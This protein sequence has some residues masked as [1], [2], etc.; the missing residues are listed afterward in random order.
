MPAVDDARARLTAH[1]ASRGLK[2]TRQRDL[3]LDAFFAAGS[4]VSADDLLR[5]V[6]GD[7]P[8]GA[9]TVYRA[10]KLFAEAGVA[11]E[12]HFHDG[13]TLYEPVLSEEHHDHLICT[14]CG[15][16]FEFEDPVIEEQQR[17]VAAAHGLV[18][19]SHRH[20]IYGTC[21]SPASCPHRS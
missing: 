2:H 7:A 18:L 10:L 12:R 11:M 13:Q 5:R 4:H 6:Q 14:T 15:K 3:I 20:E 16:I 19:H 1:M 17:R 21:A 8:V 9:A